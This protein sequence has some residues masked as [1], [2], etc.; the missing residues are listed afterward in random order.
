MHQPKSL[1]KHLQQL[2]SIVL[3]ALHVVSV[4][5]VEV[6]NL[7]NDVSL[8]VLH[9]VVDLLFQ[10]LLLVEVEQLLLVVSGNLANPLSDGVQHF[11]HIESDSLVDLRKLVSVRVDFHAVFVD[12]LSLELF[13]FSHDVVVGH[14]FIL[15]LNELLGAPPLAFYQLVHLA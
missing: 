1:L 5:F 8:E 12:Q 11:I 10:V 3:H 14:F 13:E 15:R 4:V 7:G 2:L 6:I 9:L